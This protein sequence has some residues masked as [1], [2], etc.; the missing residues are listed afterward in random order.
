MNNDTH[1]NLASC[2]A[3]GAMWL[4][5]VQYTPATRWEP[6]DVSVDDRPCPV[7]KSWDDTVY[8]DDTRYGW[9][10][11]AALEAARSVGI[12]IEML[13]PNYWYEEPLPAWL[14]E[15]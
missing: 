8:A 2:V 1:Y 11:V 6:E 10:A 4:E 7:C 5:E 12:C 15:D 13:G 14:E 9:I 3:D